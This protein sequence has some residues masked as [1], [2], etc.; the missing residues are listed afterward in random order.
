[1]N[2]PIGDFV[3]ILLIIVAVELSLLWVFIEK[4]MRA[5]AIHK[6]QPKAVN[7]PRAAQCDLGG[8]GR[9]RKEFTCR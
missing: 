1:M 4:S 7:P 5:D 8:S 2:Q 9:T 3:V 6:E